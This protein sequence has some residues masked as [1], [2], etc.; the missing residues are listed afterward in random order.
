MSFAAHPVTNALDEMSGLYMLINFVREAGSQ[1]QPSKLQRLHPVPG[2]FPGC[3][4]GFYSKREHWPSY[5]RPAPQSVVLAAWSTWSWSW[6]MK[7]ELMNKPVHVAVNPSHSAPHP[8][9]RLVAAVLTLSAPHLVAVCIRWLWVF[10]D[11][12]PSQRLVSKSGW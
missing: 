5:R 7:G 1:S 6:S 9:F 8:R 2:P 4:S 3:F 10:L 12:R 11:S